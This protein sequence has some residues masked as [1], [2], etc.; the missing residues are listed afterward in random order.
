MNI[1]IYENIYMSMYIHII[2]MYIYICVS[3]YIH[4]KY[5]IYR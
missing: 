5:G 3:M 2:Y 4:K 1:Y